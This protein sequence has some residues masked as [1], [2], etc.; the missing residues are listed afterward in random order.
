MQALQRILYVDDQQD[1]LEIGK[2]ALETLGGLTVTTCATAA[3]ALALARDP[4]A[5]PDLIVMDFSLP[6]I[7]GASLLEL[8]HQQSGWDRVLAVF[9]TAHGPEDLPG[10]LDGAGVIGQVR[11]PF[12]PLELA[13]RLRELWSA[14]HGGAQGAA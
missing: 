9:S 3:E 1:I 14:H 11:K 7:D 13:V 4:G 2:L 5:V 8:L 10:R 6:D 12:D